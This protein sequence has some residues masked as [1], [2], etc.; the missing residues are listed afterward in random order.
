MI[1]SRDTGRVKLTSAEYES[2]AND[3]SKNGY[4]LSQI[5]TLEQLLEA[6][7]AALSM[8]H[9]EALSSFL[10]QDV[11]LESKDKPSGK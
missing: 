8:E 7:I 11:P 10:E 5:D 4:K 1:I 9:Q 6:S 2:L 3:L